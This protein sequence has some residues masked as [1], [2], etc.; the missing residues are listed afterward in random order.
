MYQ[1]LWQGKKSFKRLEQ[2]D[3]QYPKTKTKQVAVAEFFLQVSLYLS[4]SLEGIS[5][6]EG[7]E[8]TSSGHL[9]MASLLRDPFCRWMSGST[10]VERY[11]FGL[12]EE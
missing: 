10:D 1:H 7:K 2:K 5:G 4:I 11:L 6:M 9:L 8:N 12:K 3:S